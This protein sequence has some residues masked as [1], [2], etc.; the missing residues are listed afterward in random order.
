MGREACTLE[1][2]QLSK[3]QNRIIQSSPRIAQVVAAAGS[4]KT[5]TV[6]QLVEDRL[7]RGIVRPGRVLLISFSRKACGEIRERLS[8][9]ARAAVEVSTFHSLA[10]RRLREYGGGGRIITDEMKSRF[11]RDFMRERNTKG[12]PYSLLLAN[13]P[14][15]RTE[16]PELC[17]EVFW[18]FACYKREAGLVEFEDLVRSMLRKLRENAMSDLQ[19]AYDLIIVDEFQDTDR[20]QLSFLGMMNFKNL[21]VVGDDYQSIYGFRGADPSIF[22]KF[23][24]H[25]K[26]AKR[27]YLNE[28]YRSLKP[29]TQ[30]GNQV[31]SFSRNQIHKRVVS[32]RKGRHPTLALSIER[33]KEESIRDLVLKNPGAR[34]LCRSNHRRFVW[35]R[36]GIPASQISTIHS[37]KGLEFPVVLLDLVGGWSMLR[38]L[39]HVPPEEVRI[40]YVGLSRA[41]NLLV[42]LHSDYTA[43]DPERLV[44]E[45]F[46]SSVKRIGHNELADVLSG[47]AFV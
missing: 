15:F 33:G 5:R 46:R 25:F 11:F 20:E 28:N 14:M 4:G 3:P 18:K 36:A 35:E 16:F 27:Y 44:F 6:V 23:R 45:M 37:A 39:T 1:C 47:L 8:P 34:I 12:I 19:N 40:A 7:A 41:E 26:D 10:Y 2:M 32:M 17:M 31:I 13:K 29:I 24:D 43:F 9:V 42:V 30:C 22:V 38:G 21:I